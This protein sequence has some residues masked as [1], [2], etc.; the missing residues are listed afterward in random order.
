MQNK[1]RNIRLLRQKQITYYPKPRIFWYTLQYND[2]WI[3]IFYLFS[4]LLAITPPLYLLILF[5]IVTSEIT[6]KYYYEK[7]AY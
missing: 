5:F 7:N 1:S 3:N 2:E 4:F 6:R